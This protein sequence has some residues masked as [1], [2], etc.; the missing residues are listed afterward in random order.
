[1]SAATKRRLD[2]IRGTLL[3][4]VAWEPFIPLWDMLKDE[5][6]DGDTEPYVGD[7]IMDTI[8]RFADERA[9]TIVQHEVDDHQARLQLVT[10]AGRQIAEE[11][12]T[13]PKYVSLL[14][15]I[16]KLGDGGPAVMF[17]TGL[18]AGKI[19]TLL[20]DEWEKE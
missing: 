15:D 1:V 18:V 2:L 14:A 19:F 3:S 12:V 4:K 8:E 9:R 10:E 11:L 16:R 7:T 13:D 5:A 6:T 17:I 20:R